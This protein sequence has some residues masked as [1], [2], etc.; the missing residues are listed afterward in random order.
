[1]DHSV[2]TSIHTTGV[3]RALSRLGIRALH[4]HPYC[5]AQ[6]VHAIAPSTREQL[7]EL[8]VQYYPEQATPQVLESFP[9]LVGLRQI[10]PDDVLTISEA[11]RTGS[12]PP[13]L[14][15]ALAATYGRGEPLPISPNTHEPQTRWIRH[16]RAR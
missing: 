3:A 1:M 7:R 5:N 14:S 6:Y 11:Q 8:F 13:T 10:S 15:R 2:N 4:Y 9:E 16:A 12:Q